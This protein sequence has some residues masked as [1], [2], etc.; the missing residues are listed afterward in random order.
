VNINPRN[1]DWRSA[2]AICIPV[3]ALLVAGRQV[4][5]SR[6]HD[7][8]TWKGGGMGMFAG[9]DLWLNRY[10]KI[11]IVDS[12]GQRQPLSDF[13]ADQADLL[14]RALNYPV[15]QNFLIAAKAIGRHDWIPR[16]E[17]RQVSLTDSNGRKI[18]TTGES[19]YWIAPFGIRA[20]G[21][22]WKWKLEI[23]YWKVSYNPLTRRA[24]TT[25]AET[26]VFKPEEL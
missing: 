11:F 9:A 21:E 2:L 10:T 13:T 19:L 24:H 12:S 23:E 20:P 3:V 1:H 4:Y 22:K 16:G 5:L 8:S 25:L 18:G 17:R 7:L 15:R 14:R 26:F 6:Y